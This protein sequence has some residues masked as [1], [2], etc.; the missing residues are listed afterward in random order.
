MLQPSHRARFL[1][2]CFFSLRLAVV[3]T[4]TIMA[5]DT[6]KAGGLSTS[7][8]INDNTN[9]TRH[10]H[11]HLN[12]RARLRHFL[13]PSGTRVHIADSPI[14]ADRLQRQL[15]NNNNNNNNNNNSQYPAAPE[16]F[17]VYISGSPEHLSAVQETQSH[18]RDRRAKL[19]KTHG[20]EVWDAVRWCHSCPVRLIR[21]PE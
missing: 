12:A 9:T 10:H 20:E 4:Y 7:L 5:N 13:H 16:P 14:E 1:F 18:H 17:S 8:P 19:R 21:G 11:H 3:L 2:F 15:S 6:E